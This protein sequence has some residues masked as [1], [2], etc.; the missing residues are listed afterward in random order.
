MGSL[1]L[2]GGDTPLPSVLPRQPTKA[3]QMTL[4]L[5][6]DPGDPRPIY[7][8]IVDE[9]RRAVLRGGLRP[10]DAVPSVRGLA[11]RLR[12]NPNTIQQAYRE[13]EREGLLEMYRGRGSFIAPGAVPS[14]RM[15]ERAAEE[16]ADAALRAATR[17]GLTAEELVEGIRRRTRDLDAD[18]PP[19][20]RRAP[21]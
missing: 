6:I 11:R 3:P 12:V 19:G 20:E 13:L 18:S 8:Q 16:V 4:V 5:D 21:A 2:Y 14:D 1:I 7:V 17:A 9:V 10:G 15:R